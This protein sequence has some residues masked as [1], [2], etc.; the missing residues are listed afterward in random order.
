MSTRPWFVGFFVAAL[1]GIGNVDA[2]ELA[3]AQRDKLVAIDTQL[4]K[5]VTLYREK[6]TEEIKELLTDVEASINALQAESTDPI[7]E[8]ILNP[9]RIRVASA[10][11][12]ADFVPPAVAAA[13]NRPPV[14]PKKPK[15]GEPTMGGVSFVK[16]VV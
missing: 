9:Y 1:M 10:H 6:K 16:D 15:P 7:M 3:P 13:A 2:A 11:K 5:V 14:T 12:L 8:A 4:Q